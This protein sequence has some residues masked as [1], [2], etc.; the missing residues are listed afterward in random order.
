MFR[1]CMYFSLTQRKKKKTHPLFEKWFAFNCGAPKSVR[2]THIAT[3]TAA[4]AEGGGAIFF[5][6]VGEGGDSPRPWNEKRREFPPPPPPLSFT[7]SSSRFFW[8]KKEEERG[9]NGPQRGPTTGMGFPIPDVSKKINIS[10][11]IKELRLFLRKTNTTVSM[12]RNLIY[13]VFFLRDPMRQNEGRGEEKARN[14]RGRQKRANRT[15]RE[16]EPSFSPPLLYY[17]AKMTPARGARFNKNF[18]LKN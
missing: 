3:T 11:T 17:E 18:L 6:G 5:E 13:I 16:K 2:I 4:A 10:V 9:N 7:S 14:N 15:E 1:C 12:F 8:A